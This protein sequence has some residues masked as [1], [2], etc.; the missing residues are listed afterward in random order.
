MK[1]CLNKLCSSKGKV[2]GSLAGVVERGDV[3]EQWILNNAVKK[4]KTK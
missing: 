2:F 4:N 3:C 1:I